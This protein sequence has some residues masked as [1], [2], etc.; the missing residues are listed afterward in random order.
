MAPLFVCFKCKSS[1]PI[2]FDQYSF[3]G[4]L[5][6]RWDA[7]RRFQPDRIFPPA[8]HKMFTSTKMQD[9]KR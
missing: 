4:E 7:Y 2:V 6:K 9:F 8:I 5:T 1:V 3:V